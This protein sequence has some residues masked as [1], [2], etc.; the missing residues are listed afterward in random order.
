MATLILGSVG[1]ALGGPL[2]GFAGAAI[3]GLID[4]LVLFPLLFPKPTIEGPRIDDR[5][6]QVASEGS[7]SKWVIGGLNRIAGTVR[8]KSDLKEV[9]TTK[10][11]GG[12]FGGGQKITSYSYFVDVAIHICDTDDLPG[13]KVF[14]VSKVWAMS[15]VIY[16]EGPTTEYESITFYLGDQT[17][18]DPLI[19]SAE[20]TGKTPSFKKTCY[21]VIKNLALANYGNQL[22]LMTFLVRQ[23]PVLHL[24][25]AVELIL[26]RYG[27]DS[28]DYDVSSLTDC[29]NGMAV[30]GNQS[31]ADVLDPLA[32]SYGLFIQEVN[33]TLV[34]K[35]RGDEHRIDVDESSLVTKTEVEDGNDTQNSPRSV[36]VTYTSTDN[37]L[38]A[39]SVVSRKLRNGSEDSLSMDLPI[40]FSSVQARQIANRVLFASTMERQKASTSLPPS[41]LYVAP[42]DILAIGSDEIYVA[43]STRG[44]NYVTEV[45]GVLTAPEIYAQNG[46]A[47]SSSG[48][49]TTFP[50]ELDSLVIDAPAMSEDQLEDIG[51][52]VVAYSD[53][54]RRAQ[55]YI[56]ADG[57]TYELS[58][59]IFSKGTFGSALRVPDEGPTGLWDELNTITIEV[60]YGTP[61]SCSELEC[62]N[63][64]NRVLIRHPS[65]EWE[66]IG[67]QNVT[68]KGN[69]QYELSRLLRGLRGTEHLV[70]GHS[71]GSDAVIVDDTVEFTSTGT[72]SINSTLYSKIVPAGAI[73]S[74]WDA[75]TSVLKGRTKKPFSPYDIA[76]TYDVSDNLTI[77]WARR[78][79]KFVGPFNSAPLSSD[80]NPLTYYLEFR[81]GGEES[82]P[83]RVVTTTTASYTYS[84]ADMTTDG[85]NPSDPDNLVNV[86]IYQVSSEVG[87]GTPGKKIITR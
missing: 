50:S 47:R 40:T 46:V 75:S 37:D 35:K 76:G 16:D 12:I 70:I 68:D 48:S 55:H 28:A 82:D 34:A 29:F 52:Y 31:G 8:W 19:E 64:T 74:E 3:G 5:S 73:V 10:K 63:G 51:V 83:V 38:Q 61:T 78:S 2:G 26:G 33:G 77:T 20:G 80:E 69:S 23:N 60:H 67:F 79:K 27:Y 66:C 56:S 65:G 17:D 24:S 4:N 18:A 21:A 11:V 9:K 57:S 41:L 53:P 87:L 1:S 15:K 14:D 49:G 58:T 71:H 54:W 6:I 44:A 84:S 72:S 25:E 43:E 32:I 7:D 62:L 45:S 36:T 39:G 13:S 42:G 85:F 86:W 81:R 30:S 59:E 22:P